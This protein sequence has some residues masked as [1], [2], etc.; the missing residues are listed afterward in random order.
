MDS[1]VP[2]RPRS[3]HGLANEVSL[4]APAFTGDR[5][6]LGATCNVLELVEVQSHAQWLLEATFEITITEEAAV[7]ILESYPE[8][9]WLANCLRRCPLPAGWTAVDSGNN[10]L[11]YVEMESGASSD[12][13]PLLSR[14]ADMGR[15][16]M[17]WRQN[18]NTV[19]D[20]ATGLRNMQHKDLEDAK[21]SRRI[22]R[23]PHKDPKSGAEFWHCPI[24]GRS[25]WG[26]PGASA[27]F[28]SRVADRL[29]RALPVPAESE[30]AEPKSISTGTTNE[31]V[32][33]VRRT[34]TEPAPKALASIDTRRCDDEASTRP[35]IISECRPETPLAVRQEE[36]RQVMSQL[37]ASAKPPASR[38]LSRP[39]PIPATVSPTL[40]EVG[41]D[42]RQQLS[43]RGKDQ[44][45]A[46]A[47][48]PGA[49]RCPAEDVLDTNLRPECRR[50][51]PSSSVPLTPM[52]AAQ[53]GGIEA[54]PVS[55]CR[56]RR[57]LTL[58]DEAQTGSFATT[59]T[60]RP[61]LSGTSGLGGTSGVI[62]Q[63]CSNAIKA[64][65]NEAL[66]P[67]YSEMI[68]DF[69]DSIQEFPNSPS[70][71]SI[72][73]HQSPTPKKRNKKA[74]S[75][76]IIIMDGDAPR[77]SS[78]KAIPKSETPQRQI[79][80]PRTPPRLGALRGLG[81]ADRPVVLGAPEPLSARARCGKDEAPLSARRRPR[82]AAGGA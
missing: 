60:R 46:A 21:R 5:N 43:S 40:L 47:A 23:G 18:P 34:K 51:R 24:T 71:M 54:R 31:E 63:M 48:E 13:S 8:L 27:E 20:A 10:R 11:R 77:W 73:V 36:V 67:G 58:G 14:M 3:Q 70:M 69:E 38:P 45:R 32:F 30:G 68:E 66:S 75:P 62:G 82:G 9:V 52:E 25:T 12:V 76:S 35:T 80:R 78:H 64:A 37:L 28:L 59:G 42:I 2:R 55:R 15:I 50:R 1:P 57:S 29:H 65:M 56:T 44:P 7:S 16:M 79:I 41:E 81:R 53:P 17:H 74:E 49:A 39:R 61:S 26:D 19:M 4:S 72:L 6:R 22:W 33:E